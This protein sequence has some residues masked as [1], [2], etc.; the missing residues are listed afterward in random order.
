MCVW[1]RLFRVFSRH[2]LDSRGKSPCV[3]TVDSNIFHKSLKDIFDLLLHD[4]VGRTKYA[5]LW[6][7]ARQRNSPRQRQFVLR[8]R[9]AW[10]EQPMVWIPKQKEQVIKEDTQK[11]LE[12]KR[13][14]NEKESGAYCAHCCHWRTAEWSI[15]SKLPQNELPHLVFV[16]HIIICMEHACL[17][18]GRGTNETGITSGMCSNLDYYTQN[19]F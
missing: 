2:T 9:V 13:F 4:A 19:P 15:P 18:S 16:C 1:Q 14:A 8:P 3:S 11:R 5:Y 6:L 17:A 10:K 7:V 12:K